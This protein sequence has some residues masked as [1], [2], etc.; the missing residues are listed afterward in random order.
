ML[1]F[2]DLLGDAPD[3]AGEVRIVGSVALAHLVSAVAVAARE[4]LDEY[5]E[6][7]YR[8]AWVEHPFPTT[9]LAAL[10]APALDR[11]L[12]ECVRPPQRRCPFARKGAARRGA[13]RWGLIPVAGLLHRNQTPCPTRRH[14]PVCVREATAPKGPS[15]RSW[16]ALSPRAIRSSAPRLGPVGSLSVG[17]RFVARHR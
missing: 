12:A 17:R 7:G 13:W 16:A 10:E 9:A 11:R 3:D 15:H 5:G 2:P 1:W 6:D 8:Q 14:F 4:V